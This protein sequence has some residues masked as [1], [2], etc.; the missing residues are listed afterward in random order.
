M[1]HRIS[2][3][4]IGA[5][6]LILGGVLAAGLIWL[7]SGGVGA[8]YN[9]YA[10]YLKSGAESLTRD[11]PV[12]YHGVRVGRV[13]SVSLQPQ[14]PERAQ[15][16]LNVRKKIVL[17]TDTAATVETRGLTGTGYVDLSGGAHNLPLLEAKPGQKYPVI[18]TKPGTLQSLTGMV[19]HVAE[20][21]TGLTD[22]LSQVLSAK[23][24]KAVSDSLEN[25]RNLTSN[26]ASRAAELDSVISNMDATLTNARAASSKL[27]ALVT[28]LH[29][30]LASYRALAAKIGS[31][32]G[33][34]GKASNRLGALAPQA[35]GLLSQ[36]AQVSQSLN[37]LVEQLSRQPNS[38]IVGRTPHPGPGESG[39]SGG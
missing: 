36:L 17:K 15:V 3:T 16:L 29:A 2:Y 37:A 35:Q 19:R 23:N 34:V 21:V 39:K 22:R 11:S 26:L 27:P 5:F 18:P 24:V 9:T 7:A 10:I 20:G 8:S 25:I 38:V 28:Q 31:A 12:L 13:A 33:S 30:T 6:V 1:E 32:A 14:H 4:V